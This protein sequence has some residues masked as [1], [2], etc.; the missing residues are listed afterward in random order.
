MTTDPIQQYLS[1]EWDC[2]GRVH[3]WRNYISEEIRL[4]WD[5]FTDEQKAALFRQAT[6]S[7]DAEEWE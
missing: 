2:Y 7:A 3:N 5:T 4:M 1:P 6:E